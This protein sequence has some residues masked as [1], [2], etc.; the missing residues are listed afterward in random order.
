MD[1]VDVVMNKSQSQSPKSLKRQ[2]SSTA[3]F[4]A[5][6]LLEISGNYNI[7]SENQCG[8]IN[9]QNNS[10]SSP[11]NYDQLL[12]KEK[13]V[14]FKDCEKHHEKKRKVDENTKKRA[15]PCEIFANMHYLISEDELK[16]YCKHHGLPTHG[17]KTNLVIRVLLHRER[18]KNVDK[19]HSLVI[20]E[21][22]NL[23]VR[24][25]D[26]IM[27]EYGLQPP[28]GNFHDQVEQCF[29]KQK[30][31]QEQRRLMNVRNQSSNLNLPVLHPTVIPSQSMMS[32]NNWSLSTPTHYTTAPVPQMMTYQYPSMMFSNV[33]GSNQMFRNPQ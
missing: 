5:E 10:S 25:A 7:Q 33:V 3:V 17:N 29:A 11:K 13:H 19:E 18:R 24:N 27:E 15:S 32:M 16:D 31:E 23:F 4:A 21:L 14:S 6:T 28:M 26:T 9:I 8:L 20:S 30:E 12:A 2:H 1:I 22:L